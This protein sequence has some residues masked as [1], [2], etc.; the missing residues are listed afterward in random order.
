[1]VDRTIEP[2][3]FYK[4]EAF[5]LAAKTLNEQDLLNGRKFIKSR[6]SIKRLFTG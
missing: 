1:M 6:D 2:N 4:A 3:V 5:N